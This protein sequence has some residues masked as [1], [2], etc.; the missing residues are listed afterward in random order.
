MDELLKEKIAHE[1]TKLE[2]YKAQFQMLDML[3]RASMQ[4][5]E[6]L[7]S[8]LTKGENEQLSEPS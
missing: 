7:K 4:A 8:Q 2:L 3:G 5:I 1:Q 6:V